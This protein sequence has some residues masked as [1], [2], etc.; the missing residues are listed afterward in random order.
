MLVLDTKQRQV[1]RIIF[2]DCFVRLYAFNNVKVYRLIDFL[3]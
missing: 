3:C 2:T 1:N